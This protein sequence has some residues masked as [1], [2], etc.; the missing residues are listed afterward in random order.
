MKMHICDIS[1]ADC[2]I[3]NRFAIEEDSLGRRECRSH[4][5]KEVEFW[6]QL[7]NVRLR[8]AADAERPKEGDN[9]S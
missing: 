9:S 7:P 4:G 8:W 6:V 5:Q 2:G 3:V 1:E